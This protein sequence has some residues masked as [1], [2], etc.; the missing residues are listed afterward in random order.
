MPKWDFR[1]PER[2][3][4][5]RKSVLDSP[6]LRD[7]LCVVSKE[8][9]MSRQARSLMILAAA[10]LCAGAT[11]P[12]LMRIGDPKPPLE[13]SPYAGEAAYLKSFTVRSKEARVKKAEAELSAQF[14]DYL[15]KVGKFSRVVDAADG[16]AD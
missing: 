3:G 8:D 10:A 9:A 2:G 14:I 6:A 11:P 13:D 15:A 4:G 12:P 1:T 16:S 5:S 7:Y